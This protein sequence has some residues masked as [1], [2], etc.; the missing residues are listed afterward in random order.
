M[1]KEIQNRQ[2]FSK[3]TKNFKIDKKIQNWQKYSKFAKNF[4]IDKKRNFLSI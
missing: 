2:K 3:L 1:D 4:K